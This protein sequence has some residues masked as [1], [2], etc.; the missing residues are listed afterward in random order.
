[1]KIGGSVGIIQQ[2]FTGQRGV[3]LWRLADCQVGVASIFKIKSVSVSR[4][5]D[6]S[7]LLRAGRRK[8]RGSEGRRVWPMGGCTVVHTGILSSAV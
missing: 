6:L 5:G 8:S 7:V 1:M 3:L 2:V 4:A